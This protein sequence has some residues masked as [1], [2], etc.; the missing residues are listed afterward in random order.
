VVW[1]VFGEMKRRRR[2]ELQEGG[3]VGRSEEEEGSCVPF[4]LI[5]FYFRSSLPLAFPPS[6]LPVIRKS[7][8]LKAVDL[9]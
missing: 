8:A 9:S 5:L 2:G 3:K 4:S 7:S 1:S 6:R